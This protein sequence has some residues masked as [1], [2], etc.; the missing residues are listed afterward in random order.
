MSLIVKVQ[1]EEQ[2]SRKMYTVFM[3][4]VVL[5]VIVG[6]NAQT[7]KIFEEVDGLLS[8]EAEHWW[9]Q[10]KTQHREWLL[11]DADT[12]DRDNQ[13]NYSSTAS[14]GA[15]MEIH[16]FTRRQHG[17][18]LQRGINFSNNGG[19]T[20][21]IKYRVYFNNPGRYYVWVSTHSR[22]TEDNGVHV[23]FNGR[24]PST[25]ERIQWCRD[26]RNW[27]WE[28]RQR[29]SAEH[30][31]VPGLIYLDVTDTGLQTIEFSLREDGFRMDK[32]FMT[33]DRNFSRPAVN[34]PGPPE[35]PIYGVDLPSVSITSPENNS[36]FAEPADITITADASVEDGSISKVEFFNGSDLLGETTSS[37]YGY[38]WNDVPAGTYHLAAKATDNEGRSRTSGAVRVTVSQTV[39]I[40]GTIQAQE[41][42]AGSSTLG[43]NTSA[44]EGGDT[45]LGAINTGSWMEYLVSVEQ[46]GRYAA[47]FRVATPNDDAVMAMKNQDGDVLCQLE[48]PNTGA[49]PTFTTIRDTVELEEGS[50][51]LRLESVE[52]RWNINWF[53]LEALS[54]TNVKQVQNLSRG[55]QLSI[56][57]G[58]LRYM[59]SENANA[60][61][62]VY[63]LR[64]RM[65]YSRKIAAKA[66]GIQY[67]KIPVETLSIGNYLLK[68]KTENIEQ[69]LVFNVFR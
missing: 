19:E 12:P 49:W 36:A 65:V 33:K 58:V 51:T 15:Y 55:N 14:G 8:V 23:G 34:S 28:S 27:S 52:G 41:Y 56:E 22:G 1:K 47:E 25:G 2:M 16:P 43:T 67:T 57:N 42:S 11:V 32:W 40:P 59:L 24:W 60:A 30:C 46:A 48:I 3:S 17:D 63:D 29:T 37:P 64:G 54:G 68:F 53:K 31:G 45:Y 6:A 21:I 61:I 5:L 13:G 66:E 4:L 26:K 35:S 10:D 9:E 20:C 38:T 18:P 44:S 62:A 50:Q 7:D 69:E 39:T